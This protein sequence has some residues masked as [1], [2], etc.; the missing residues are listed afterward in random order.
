MVLFG[1]VC[2][3]FASYE[4]MLSYHIISPHRRHR[5]QNHFRPGRNSKDRKS[6]GLGL[7]LRGVLVVAAAG[8]AVDVDVGAAAA[9]VGG[10]FG[11]CWTS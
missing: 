4:H 7:C 6:L 2:L 10:D 9:G 11:G 5:Q 1:W 8:V 3:D